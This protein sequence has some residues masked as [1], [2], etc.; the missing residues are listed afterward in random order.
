MII[1]E[2]CVHICP[3]FVWMGAGEVDM[4]LGMPVVDYV[5]ATGA[6]VANISDPR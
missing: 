1:C 5:R 3:Q 4:K 6:I 2:A